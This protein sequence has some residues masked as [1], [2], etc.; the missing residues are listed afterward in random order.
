MNKL[1]PDYLLL[2]KTK[3]CSCCNKRMKVNLF[4]KDK[5][6]NSGYFTYCK[7]CEKEYQRNRR[8]E[9]KNRKLYS[10]DDIVLEK[11]TCSCCNK[12]KS[13]TEFYL[14]KN[15]KSGLSSQCITCTKKLS[16]K[17]KVNNPGNGLTPY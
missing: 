2:M 5:Y 14:N 9:V 4:R 7:V 3:I 1:F 11:K 15:V 6:A 16:K 10:H 17:Y 8:E 12:L 13:K